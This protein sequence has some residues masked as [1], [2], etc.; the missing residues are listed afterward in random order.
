MQCPA[1]VL[2]FTVP[3]DIVATN[4]TPFVI[5]ESISYSMKHDIINDLYDKAHF[6]KS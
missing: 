2:V 1:V 5:Q 4:P 3:L 6:S